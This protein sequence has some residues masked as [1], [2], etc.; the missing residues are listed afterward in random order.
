MAF[1][2]QADAAGEAGPGR[3]PL[4]QPRLRP[5]AVDQPETCYQP[6]EQRYLGHRLMA[7]VPVERVEG[8]HQGRGIGGPRVGKPADPQPDRNQPQK[9]ERGHGPLDPSPVD[10]LVRAGDRRQQQERH[11]GRPHLMW[12][13]TVR[14]QAPGIAHAVR[15]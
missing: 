1:D 8:E 2:Q 13:V 6:E 3:L 14:R 15:E 4:R 10:H 7:E 12:H 5:T 11:P 9:T